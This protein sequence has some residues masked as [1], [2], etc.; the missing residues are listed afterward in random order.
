MT[1]SSLMPIFVDA[2]AVAAFGSN[3]YRPRRGR[4]LLSPDANRDNDPPRG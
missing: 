4:R 3:P 2:A 1:E